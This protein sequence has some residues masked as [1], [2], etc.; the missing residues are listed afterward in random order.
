MWLLGPA[1]LC[2]LHECPGGLLS[3]CVGIDIVDAPTRLV[4]IWGQGVGDAVSLVQLKLGV[5][6]ASTSFAFI[7]AR[8]CQPVR[9]FD[10]LCLYCKRFCM[11]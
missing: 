1:P 8:Y 6:I 9:W 5:L 3:G 2:A 11:Y 7:S 10:S 4:K